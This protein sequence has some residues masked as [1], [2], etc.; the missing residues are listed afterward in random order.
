M[1]NIT[2]IK[3][4]LYILLA[5]MCLVHLILYYSIVYIVV[6]IDYIDHPAL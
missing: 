1:D 6:Y 3:Q 4:L 2:N 5:N